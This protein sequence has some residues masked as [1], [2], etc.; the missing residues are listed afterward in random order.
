MPETPRVGSA[1][2]SDAQPPFWAR[3]TPP[4]DTSAQGF[5]A[6]TLRYSYPP[7]AISTRFATSNSVWPK[8]TATRLMVAAPASPATMNR[9]GSRAFL[10]RTNTSTAMIGMMMPNCGLT[11]A[12]SAVSAA[13][14]TLFPRIS[15]EVAKR[16]REVPTASTW[17]HTAESIQ[18]AGSSAIAAAATVAPRRLAPR[19]I[20]SR[21]VVITRNP[22]AM[23]AGSLIR[24]P[25]SVAPVT[26][27]A[28]TPN[29]QSRAR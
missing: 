6:P 11:T 8:G 2:T 24:A 16:R 9:H 1:V 28:T 10:A 17:P 20:A 23:I 21:A 4:I 29:G 5:H 3:P 22:S 13:A 12:A 26:A 7:P 15:S 14:R 18:V 25:G 19:S 27:P